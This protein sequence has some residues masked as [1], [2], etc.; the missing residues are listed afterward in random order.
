MNRTAM[1][2]GV[3]ALVAAPAGAEAN[4]R[5]GKANPPKG[6]SQGS[7]T[8][9]EIGL[10]GGRL[11]AQIS[12]MTEELRGYFGAPGDAGV[13]VARVEADS[14]AAKAGL[15]VGDVVVDV[16]GRKVDDPADVVGA[17]AG[18]GSGAKVSL[19][20]VRDKRRQTLSASLRDAPAM[21]GMGD[22]DMDMDIDVGVPRM[23][24]GRGMRGFFGFDKDEIEKLTKQLQELEQRLEK[25][26]RRSK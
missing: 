14:P 13:L 23:G 7:H 10:S 2:V 8:Y 26:E 1:V 22:M 6:G 20:V 15:K 24:K 18:K 4:G 11:G 19:G 5:D 3:F 12:S 9:F 17:L 25:L 21:Q 16:D